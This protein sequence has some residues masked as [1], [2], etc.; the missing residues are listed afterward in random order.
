MHQ[1]LEEDAARNPQNKG[2]AM[3]NEAKRTK[4]HG[5]TENPRKKMHENTE[6]TKIFLETL[7]FLSRAIGKIPNFFFSQNSY[8][9]KIFKNIFKK[10]LSNF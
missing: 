6:A 9:Q 2:R 10:I 7:E 8:S 1:K 5:H 4:T 3:C